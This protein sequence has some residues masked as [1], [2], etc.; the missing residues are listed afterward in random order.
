MKILHRCDY[1]DKLRACH[2]PGVVSVPVPASRPRD[3]I[4]DL[5]LKVVGASVAGI[6]T[7]G[8]V[9]AVG[10]AVTYVRF[11]RAGLAA[12]DAVAVQPKAVL[13]TLGAEV[14]VPLAGVIVFGIALF[15]LTD[16]AWRAASTM[17]APTRVR[18]IRSTRTCSA[19][20]RASRPRSGTPG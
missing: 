17:I 6:G 8:F 18:R 9:T 20:T 2:H 19:A 13:L 10:G 12:E 11:A 15:F 16:R 14:L 5:A 4:S 3:P 7:L 1:P